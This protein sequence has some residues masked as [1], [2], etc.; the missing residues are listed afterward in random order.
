MKDSLKGNVFVQQ[1]SWSAILVRFMK[2]YLFS[3]EI[4]SYMKIE[5]E[6]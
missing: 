5:L 6:S 1:K 2:Q 4:M 3:I